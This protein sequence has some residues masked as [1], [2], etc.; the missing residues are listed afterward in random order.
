MPCETSAALVAVG[1]ASS[2]SDSLI[3]QRPY[4]SGRSGPQRPS[5]AAVLLR[6]ICPDGADDFALPF[7][8]IGTK[9]PTMSFKVGKS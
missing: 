8:R 1:D 4:R 3:A 5:T 7:G 9:W 6:E 2:G